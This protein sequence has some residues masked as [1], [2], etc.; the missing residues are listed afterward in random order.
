[1]ETDFIAIGRPI[2]QS[3]NIIEAIEKIYSEISQ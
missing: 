2:T 3:G 1:M